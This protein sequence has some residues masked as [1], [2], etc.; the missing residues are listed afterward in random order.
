MKKLV[1]IVMFIMFLFLPQSIFAKEWE[2]KCDYTIYYIKTESSGEVTDYYGLDVEAIIYDDA[3]V[4][5][6]DIKNDKKLSGGSN[7]TP[8]Y[9]KSG[10]NVSA[11]TMQL[12][13]T[14]DFLE[15][16][17][18]SSGYSCPNLY[19]ISDISAMAS[20]VK[21]G[22]A[23]D[24]A[25]ANQYQATISKQEVN[26]ASTTPEVKVNQECIRKYRGKHGNIDLDLD[27]YFRIY[28]N[29][30][31]EFCLKNS[32][33][34][35]L[36]C[37]KEFTVA[38]GY[39]NWEYYVSIGNDQAAKIFEQGNMA[40][41]N[42]NNFNCPAELYLSLINDPPSD[43]SATFFITMDESETNNYYTVI[44]NESGNSREID[45]NIIDGEEVTGCEVIPPVIRKW[46]NNI[47]NFVKYVALAL[48]IILG[49][50]DFI[51][52]A[53]S[54]EPDQMK[55]SGQAF[56]KRVIAVVILFLLPYII[57]LILN[58]VDLAGVDKNNIDCMKDI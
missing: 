6:L 41:I 58:L 50:L 33:S 53:A 3:T 56:L 1:L 18:L 21:I 27:F 54:G 51:K 30:T 35:S 24:Y 37:S 9:D 15:N 17:K 16:S 11:A 4:E 12:P 42:N 2:L 52:A 22:D 20:S 43:T 40:M 13:S 19:S 10:Y 28:T 31:K 26:S 47:L 49:V 38:N 14:G 39:N 55:K 23:G 34:D 29:G 46:I 36:A 25:E 45:T 32:A 48:V 5:Y 44:L 8:L 57:D 7:N